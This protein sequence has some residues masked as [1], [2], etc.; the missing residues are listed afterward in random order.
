MSA[1][2]PGFVC[3]LPTEAR[4][5]TSCPPGEIRATPFGLVACSG[6]GPERAHQSASQLI[7]LGVT[8]LISFGTA[9]GLSE[10]ARP[11]VLCV[12][13][14]V[15]TPDGRRYT[16]TLPAD[17]LDRLSSISTV[18]RGAMLDCG[19]TPL[20]TVTDKRR[21]ARTEGRPVAVDMESGSIALVAQSAGIP[22]AAVRAVVDPID[23]SL[24]SAALAAIDGYGRVRFNR[25][26]VELIYKPWQIF[27]LGHLAHCSRQ[28]HRTLRRV[29]SS[30]PSLEA[31]SLDR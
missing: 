5:L 15:L 18:L 7:R 1:S 12:P 22:F 6:I 3:A 25:M 28:G 20:A 27:S 14:V 19:N 23:T 11:G 4:A 26:L 30:W 31:L 21:A 8:S 29:A 17:V 13:E 9:G 2:G 10:T 16:T 24:P